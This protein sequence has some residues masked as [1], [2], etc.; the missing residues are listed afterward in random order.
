MLVLFIVS[1][2][3]ISGN[4]LKYW[5]VMVTVT[6]YSDYYGK[7]SPEILKMFWWNCSRRLVLVMYVMLLELCKR[8]GNKGYAPWPSTKLSDRSTNLSVILS[9]FKSVRQFSILCRSLARYFC[10]FYFDLIFKRKIR[11]C[12][13]RWDLIQFNSFANIPS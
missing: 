3:I 5:L 2:I 12:S 8:D 6:T 7:G 10:S 1:K 9:A 11:S 4:K 13:S